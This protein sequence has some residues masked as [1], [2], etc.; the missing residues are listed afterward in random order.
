[1]GGH[2][3]IGIDGPWDVRRILGTVP[4]EADGSASFTVPANTPIAVQPLDAEG[5]AAAADAELVHGHAGRESLLRRLPRDAEHHARRSKPT[6]ASQR[7]PSE[8]TPVVRPGARLQLR[9]RSP[10]GARQVLR[11]LPRRAA[12]AATA[13]TLPDFTRQGQERLAQLHAVLRRA[14]PLRAPARARRATTTC[15]CRWSSTPTPANWCRCSSKGHHNVKLDAEAWDRLITWID[16][17]VPDHGTWTEHVGG[18][19]RLSMQRRLEMRTQVRQPH[20]RSRR[21]SRD[22]RQ[23]AG[24]VRRARAACRSASRRTCALAGWPFDAAE[25]QSAAGRRR[26]AGRR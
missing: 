1:M 14:A 10:A 4:V 13:S 8:I 6:L 25:A 19:R 12:A 15:R 3:N 18:P 26:T 5:K 16:L 23:R 20:R 2:I 7:Q 22:R 21:R 9:A 17:N 24:R 11:R